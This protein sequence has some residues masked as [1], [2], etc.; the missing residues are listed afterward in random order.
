MLCVNECEGHVV[1]KNN[2]PIWNG[3][4]GKSKRLQEAEQFLYLKLSALR[5]QT[6]TDYMQATFVFY[7]P[8]DK[9]YTKKGTVSKLLADLSNLYELPQDQ[10]TKAGI[11]EDDRLIQSH[12]G[13]RIDLSQNNPSLHPNYY[14]LHIR[15]FKFTPAFLDVPK[16][17]KPKRINRLGL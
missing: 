11:I 14:Y 9:I 15:L 7:Y 8:Y 13:S 5:T 12:D 3:R 17:E 10:L 6:I 2:R 1:K 4:P 16:I